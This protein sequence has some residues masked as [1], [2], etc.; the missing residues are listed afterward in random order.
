MITVMQAGIKEKSASKI[1]GSHFRWRTQP[2]RS[3]CL[4]AGL[5]DSLATLAGT[6]LILVLTLP[7]HVC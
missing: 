5:T 7:V 4:S 2:I 3:T 6:L 1:G